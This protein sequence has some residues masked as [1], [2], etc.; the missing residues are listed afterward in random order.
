M[1]IVQVR[2]FA[3]PAVNRREILRYAGCR[4]ETEDVA[5]LLDDCLAQA[6]PVLTYA[7]CWAEFAVPEA[8][9]SRDLR[10]NLAGCDRVVAFAATVGIGIDRLIAR[11]GRIAPSKAVLFQ[12]IGAERI[13]ALCDAFQQEIGCLRPR[14]SPGYGDLP[15]AAQRR[16]FRVL[17]PERHIGVSLN[18]TLLMAP[19]KSVTALIGIGSA[20]GQCRTHNCGSCTLY[21]CQFR[22]A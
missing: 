10:K 8:I 15:L 5:K 6:L 21:H 3:A 14:F 1:S 18:D 16:I 20:E 2:H 17:S 22:K 19:S 12:A 11:S 7:V 13:E 9:A 4:A